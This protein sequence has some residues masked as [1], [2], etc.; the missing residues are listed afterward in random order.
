ML[1]GTAISVHLVEV[2]PKLSQVQAQCLTGDQ[3]QVSASENDPAYR[4]GTTSTGLPISWYRR[5]DDVPKG[6]RWLT[7]TPFNLFVCYTLISQ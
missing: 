4:M 5:I 2:S 1:S 6:S 7:Q 3:S